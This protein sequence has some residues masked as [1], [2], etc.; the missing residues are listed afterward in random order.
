VPAVEATSTG[1]VL[2]WFEDAEPDADALA[3][4]LR[5]ADADVLILGLAAFV[6]VEVGVAVTH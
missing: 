6:G 1:L 4:A 2:E 5:D 3:D